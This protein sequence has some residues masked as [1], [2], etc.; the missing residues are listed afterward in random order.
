MAAVEIDAAAA[1][2]ATTEA[3][4]VDDGRNLRGWELDGGRREGL[5]DEDDL[6]CCKLEGVELDTGRSEG[7]TT[8]DRH[9]KNAR[10]LEGCELDSDRSDE[11]D[12]EGCEIVGSEL[13]GRTVHDR[14]V[15]NGRDEGG[16]RDHEGCDDRGRPLR[17]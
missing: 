13:A 5:D 3:R 15:E 1:R 4:H 11:G 2:A 10:D 9:V 17:P 8:K 7:I 14:H 6:K 12:L 16:R